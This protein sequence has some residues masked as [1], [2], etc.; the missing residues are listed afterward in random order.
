MLNI[1]L[2]GPPGAGK[3]TQSKLLM[4]KYNLTYIS[5]GDILRE[6]IKEGTHIGGQAKGLIEEGKLVPDELIVQIIEEKIKM[7]PGA[8]GFL[9]DGFPRTFVQC[10]ILEGLLLKLNTTLSCMLSLEVPREQLIQRLLDRG[11]T[12]GRSDDSQEVINHRLK[13]YEEK[14]LPVASYYEEQKKYFPIDGTE[15]VEN[16]NKE[17]VCAVE[18][19]LQKKWLNVVL[20]GPPGSGKGTQAKKLAKK[21]N[22]VYVSTGEL[23]RNEI[24]EKTEIGEIAKS[25]MDKGDVV[26]DRI[27]IQ[28]IESKIKRNTNSKGF[29]FKGFPSTIVQAYILDGLLRKM[30]SKLSLVLDLEATTLQSVKRL[31]AR[32]KTKKARSYDMDIE[33]VLHRLEVFEE[34]SA[35]VAEYYKKQNKYLS[36]SGDGEEEDVYKH[37][38]V[39][40]DR[41]FTQVR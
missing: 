9:F 3:G 19:T 41:A 34:K 21:F 2:F 26:P 12:E 39:A 36:F 4:K 15:S 14:T 32:S 16:V 29:I 22:L 18:K 38:E 20:F 27:A 7:S 13:E 17:L 25:F 24:A 11:T 5:T 31:T 35:L 30:D 6:E 23:L 40:I 33:I 10:Y 1:A 37:L 8:N 28:L